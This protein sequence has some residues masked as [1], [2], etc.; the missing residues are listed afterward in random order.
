MTTEE[1]I[2]NLM[3]NDSEN[4]GHMTEEQAADILDWTRGDDYNNEIPA[5]LTAA[6]LARRWN[7]IKGT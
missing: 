3:D 5:D 1:F 7:E 6:E 2:L 4:I